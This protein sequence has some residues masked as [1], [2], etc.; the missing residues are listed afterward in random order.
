MVA[1][2]FGPIPKT[3]NPHRPKDYRLQP[4]DSRSHRLL[5]LMAGTPRDCRGNLCVGPDVGHGLSLRKCLRQNLLNATDDSIVVRLTRHQVL[6]NHQHI[7]SVSALRHSVVR[8]TWIVAILGRFDRLTLKCLCLLVKTQIVLFILK[9]DCFLQACHS[10]WPWHIVL[11]WIH[12]KFSTHQNVS[13]SG[14]CWN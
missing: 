8:W 7:Y 14:I 10:C 1:H 11:T 12:P 13:R 5:E 9:S 4:K 2:C 6:S 3:G